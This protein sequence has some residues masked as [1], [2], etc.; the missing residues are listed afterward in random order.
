LEQS[1]GI[2]LQNGEENIAINIDNKHSLNIEEGFMNI[3][4]RYDY[5][6]FK[7][8]YR[9]RPSALRRVFQGYLRLVMEKAPP[10]KKI[11]DVGCSFG[12]FLSLCD[13]EGYE[14]FGV[15][16]SKYALKR[17]RAFTKA[18]LYKCDVCEVLPFPNDFFDIVTCFDTLEHL[19]NID[20][21]LINI[22]SVLKLSGFFYA[23]TPNPEAKFFWK[24]LSNMEYDVTHIN[25]QNLLEPKT[26][27]MRI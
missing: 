20:R 11:L 15:D 24:L 26:Q 23:N 12:F 7:K 4:D 27:T 16:I 5:D 22:N 3:E 14:T 9:D 19:D 2:R 8:V 18:T 6:Y 10:P 21:A 13:K 25:V 1:Y 17:A